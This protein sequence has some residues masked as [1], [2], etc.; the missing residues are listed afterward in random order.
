MRVWLLLGVLVSLTA[1]SKGSGGA[2]T[3]AMTMTPQVIQ[4]D[5]SDV[6]EDVDENMISSEL[7]ALTAECGDLIAL[8]GSAMMGMLTNA[9]VI[10]LEDS[11]ADAER[12]TYRD[13]LSRVL[14]NDAYGKG[15]MDRWEGMVARHLGAV[16]RSDPDLCYSFATHLAKQGPHRA[17][18]AIK[19]ADDALANKA[20]WV[21]ETYVDRV[22]ALYRIRA[23]SAQRWWAHIEQLNAEGSEST[24]QQKVEAS[25][26][27]AKTLAR[28]WLEYAKSAGRDTTVAMQL[29]IS[30]AG[31]SEYCEQL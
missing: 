22:N 21:G 28:E 11:L 12:Q 17:K 25:R 9:E 8:E 13:K 6:F 19:Q 20:V 3:S 4:I 23:I 1:C 18:E 10:C 15:N 27:D 29:C 5:L 24:D 16:G 7:L 14:M 30:S 31:T 26:N 2:E